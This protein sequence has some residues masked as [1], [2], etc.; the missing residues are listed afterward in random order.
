MKKK[1]IIALTLAFALLMVFGVTASAFAP[2]ETYTYSIS[3]DPMPSPSAYEAAQ[4]S[5]HTAVTMSENGK[6]QFSAGSEEIDGSNIASLF[7]DLCTDSRGWV[8]LSDQNKNRVIALNQNY[9][10]QYI[11]DTFASDIGPTDT[12]S[13]PRG[14]FATDEYLYVCDTGNARIVVFNTAD[15]SYHKNIAAPESNVFGASFVFQPIALA[16]DKFNKLFVVSK[17]VTEG[18]IVMDEDSVF[19]GFIGAQKVVIS[20]F[21]QFFRRFKS[22]E[23]RKKDILN[24][25]TPLRNITLEHGKYG[26]FLYVVS[27]S[28]DIQQQYATIDSK[29]ADYSPVR[30]INNK[31]D[32][33]MKR[34]GFFDCGGEVNVAASKLDDEKEGVSKIIDVATG[35]EDA[36]TWSIIDRRRSK[37]YTYDRSGQLLFVF[38]DTN[39]TESAQTGQIL[40]IGAIDYQYDS[41]NDSYNIL[42]L[43][44]NTSIQSFTVF[45][46][47]DYGELLLDAIVSDNNLDYEKSA[48]CW[49]NL[50]EA[51]NNFDAA[52]IGYGKALYNKGDYVGALKYLAA[53]KE[54]DIYS[55]TLK[56]Q[57]QE[58]ISSNALIPLLIV[59]AVLVGIF[60]VVKIFGY[61]KRVNYQGNFKKKHTYWEE[62]IYAFYVIFHPFDGFWDIKHEGRGT[63]RGGLT[64]LG[65]NILAFYYQNI[66]RSYLANP[67]G[68]YSAFWTQIAAVGIPVVLWA[69]A[70][71]CLTTLFDGEAKFKHVFVA[72][73]YALAPLPVFVVAGTIITNLSNTVGDSIVTL[74]TTIGYV[75]V[76]FLLFFGTLVVQ[77]YSLGKN[78]FTTIGTI[79]C[80]VVIMFV[81]ILF[82]SLVGD[83][84]GFVSNLVTE[85]SFRT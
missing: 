24:V 35:P 33:I 41:D 45:S 57:S 77:D 50:L 52:Y 54:T 64:I 40:N 56:A 10:A 65:I 5:V 75:W 63:V 60:I 78:V 70:N 51:N 2:Y 47:T 58:R 74:V 32:E 46:C 59:V 72:S 61:A 31:G 69:V 11:I 44:N 14:L 71:W 42:I 8:Y 30:K 15:G 49:W 83:M 48:Q 67:T 4:G 37:V 85:I 9:K 12:L 22:E 38:G 84:V 29:K 27:D 34:N 76:A 3:G 39:G 36:G 62:L 7:A 79:L 25:A 6:V 80:M 55:D 43:D 20:A 66:G 16:V 53:A 81:V 82:A 26:D 17:D 23:E 68:Q 73:C 13:G 28:V 19:T 18:V 21:D 1:L